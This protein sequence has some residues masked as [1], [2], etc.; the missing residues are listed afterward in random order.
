MKRFLAILLTLAFL[1]VTTNAFGQV[2]RVSTR[3]GSRYSSEATTG[4]CGVTRQPILGTATI[5]CGA[6]GGTAVVRYPFTL[7]S[8]CGPGVSPTVDFLGIV[9]TVSARFAKGTVSVAVHRAG[10]GKTV[11]STVSISYYCG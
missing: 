4:N 7:R 9:P 2:W 11:I 1:A 6:G 5:S 8:G 10:K 3:W